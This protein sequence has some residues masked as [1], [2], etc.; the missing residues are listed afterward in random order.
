MRPKSGK[1]NGL[2]SQRRLTRSE[3]I[4]NFDARGT[5]SFDPSDIKEKD[6]K[7]LIRYTGKYIVWG[8]SRKMGHGRATLD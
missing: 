2:S 7:E 3:V 1:G 6:L 8:A 4:E 5:L